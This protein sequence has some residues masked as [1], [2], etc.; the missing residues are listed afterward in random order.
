MC[1][2][3]ENLASERGL[4]VVLSFHSPSLAVRGPGSL[5]ATFSRGRSTELIELFT[6]HGFYHDP[7][8][9]LS[10]TTQVLL[11]CLLVW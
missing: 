6:H 4:L 5:G 10:E 8:D 9:A 11:D 2:R 7:N 3:C 1:A